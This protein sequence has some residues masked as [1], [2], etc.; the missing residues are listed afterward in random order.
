MP[1]AAVGYAVGALFSHH[2]GWGDAARSIWWSMFAA[3]ALAYAAQNRPRGLTRWGAPLFAA[4]GA[5]L[6]G[7]LT[8]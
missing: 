2:F 6:F 7:P 4:L 5:V 8:A 3:S 1:A